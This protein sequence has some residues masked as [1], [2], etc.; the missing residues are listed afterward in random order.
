MKILL[1]KERAALFFVILALLLFN[2]SCQRQNQKIRTNPQISAKIKPRVKPSYFCPLDG[3]KVESEV[4]K[5]AVAVM[6]ENLSTI[7]PQSGLSS[8]CIVFEA[9]AEGGITRFLAVYAHSDA[10]EVG[11]V[12]SARTYYVAL[13]RGL[14]AL[15]AHCGGSIT[16]MKAVKQWG[17][18]DLDQFRYSQAYWRKKGVAAP[19]NLYTS[20]SKVREV[21][22]KAGLEVEGDPLK[23]PHKKDKPLSGRPFGQDITIDFSSP[24][25]R[26]E[27]NYDQN[28]NTYLRK[29][30]GEPHTDRANG[31]QLAAHNVIVLFVPTSNSPAGSGLLD[32]DIIGEGESLVFRDGV[33]EEGIWQKNSAGSSLRFLEEDGKEFKLNKGQTW[34]EIVKTDTPVNYH[35][36]SEEGEDS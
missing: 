19:H 23:W 12:R 25:Y 27:Y 6:V 20:I 21:A 2:I 16:A 36:F 26:V 17:V 13:A 14:D 18:S 11:P 3:V 31:K 33:V 35:T 15:Y 28:S 22:D 10:Q 32:I 5:R 1:T 34:V 7:R 24:A 30:G 9:L 8:A 29:N 4:E